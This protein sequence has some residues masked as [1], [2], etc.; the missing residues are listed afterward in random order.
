MGVGFR[1]ITLVPVAI[2]AASFTGASFIAN[3]QFGQATIPDPVIGPMLGVFSVSLVTLKII[4]PFIVVD[5][6][7]NHHRGAVILP[8]FL[9]VLIFSWCWFG[10]C[11][12]VYS[13]LA[14]STTPSPALASFMGMEAIDVQVLMAGIMSLYIELLSGF[15]PLIMVQGFSRSLQVANSAKRPFSNHTSTP[16]SNIVQLPVSR[17]VSGP[18]REF[19]DRRTE[20]NEHTSVGA[21]DLYLAFK[22]YCHVN[23]V[24][25]FTQKLFGETMTALNF[26]RVR[27]GSNG[28][29]HYRCIQLKQSAFYAAA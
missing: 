17:D 18:V 6:W 2:A 27:L 14:T 16:A 20:L 15:L 10:S 23:G 7:Q 28:R 29:Y 22:S 25:P 4:V 3:W 11:F 8:A 21:S 1:Y 13:L 26:E 12:A 9:W 5:L 19:L 24:T